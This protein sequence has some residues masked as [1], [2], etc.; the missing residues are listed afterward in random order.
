MSK[1]NKKTTK[2]VKMFPQ[3]GNTTTLTT[4]LGNS[5]FSTPKPKPKPE[6]TTSLGSFF[7]APKPQ[8]KSTTSMGS[9]FGTPKNKPTTWTKKLNENEPNS[10]FKTLEESR[11]I[12]NIYALGQKKEKEEF[13]SEAKVSAFLV[14]A[15]KAACATMK[16]DMVFEPFPEVIS[17]K[18]IQRCREALKDLP[19]LDDKICKKSTKLKDELS[20][21]V[22]QCLVDTASIQ[23]IPKDKQISFMG[24]DLQFV[25][26]RCTPEKEEAF[27][28]AKKQ[29]GSTFAFHGSAIE[30]WH[31]II[32]NGLL[33]G[34]GTWRENNGD[35]Y[36]AGIYMTPKLS[37][38]I[39]YCYGSKRRD[40]DVPYAESNKIC[41]TICEVIKRPDLEK[42]DG[43][44]V[45][46]D[47]DFVC[48]RFFCVFNRNDYIS[49][50]G[51]VSTSEQEYTEEIRKVLTSLE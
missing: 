23:F 10:F 13:S 38:A 51:R 6:P 20:S 29:Y 18:S 2:G 31:S 15:A 30:N 27:S 45:T 7:G 5:F 50:S 37:S 48:T 42:A 16:A 14:T 40:D 19:D 41:V 11:K 25:K 32:R 24:T 46:P 8:P 49:G 9:F 12:L 34:S 44:W 21:P 17:P 1:D 4:S 28:Q 47:E 3:N 39:N 22:Q 26:T 35:R 43:I 36:G 33:R